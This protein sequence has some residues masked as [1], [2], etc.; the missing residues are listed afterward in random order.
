MTP[1]GVT[2]LP[3]VVGESLARRLFGDADPVGRSIIM[4]NEGNSPV[5]EAF[6]VGVARDVAWNS[7][8]DDRPLFLY[9][10]Y[11]QF[12]RGEILLVR[13]T[14]PFSEISRVVESVAREV[15]P[16]LPVS[17]S[18]PLSSGIESEVSE[19]RTFAWVLSLVGW[20][21]FAL[22]A[23]GLYGLLAQ[24]VS[25]RTREFGIRLAIGSGR[26]RIFALVLYQ[27]AWIGIVGVVG[28]VLLAAFGTRMIQA[29]LVGV[30]R[31][32][33]STYLF[34]TVVLTAVVFLAGLWPARTATRIEPAEALRVE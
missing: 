1:S 24:S 26:T 10:P 8:T 30:T 20:I 4:P 18:Q 31:L 27:A 11:P 6:V 21:A 3:V 2:T 22:A 12:Y 16:T 7:L 34:A 29:Q 14:V 17:F 32:D 15:D 19:Q 5:R 33:V 28:G 9:Q 25:E 13:S 23:V